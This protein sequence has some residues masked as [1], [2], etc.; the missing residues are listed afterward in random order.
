ADRL[1]DGEVVFVD[2]LIGRL[3]GFLEKKG[4]YSQSSL[5]FTSDHGEDL[6]DHGENTHGFFVYD[7]TLLVPLIIKAPTAPRGKVIDRPV[8]SV[9]IAPTILE[10]LSLPRG[11]EMQ[12]KGLISLA[13]Q[14]GTGGG[15][16]LGETFYP[17]F[18][19]GWSPLRFLRTERFKY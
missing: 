18:H 17:F 19:F 4:W 9:D 16:A 6:G 12:G 8:Q 10:M 15:A 13:T 1:Y 7:S 3:T 5:I 2:S 11:P 14:D